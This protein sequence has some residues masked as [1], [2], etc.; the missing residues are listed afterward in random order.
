MNYKEKSR[1]NIE[2]IR[3][4]MIQ[5]KMQNPDL[6]H[7]F[8]PYFF[9]ITSNQMQF[10]NI[11]T[12]QNLKYVLPV[13]SN[14][15]GEHIVNKTNLLRK[16]IECTISHL[17]NNSEFSEIEENCFKELYK[18]DLF[19]NLVSFIEQNKELIALILGGVVL[20]K[21]LGGAKHG[22]NYDN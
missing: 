13:L 11:L 6:Y 17:K 3:D 19:S 20:L 12:N 22:T 18:V 9:L 2:A 16:C 15:L 8:M 5:L 7:K 21:Y 1:K 10:E 14:Y 4:M